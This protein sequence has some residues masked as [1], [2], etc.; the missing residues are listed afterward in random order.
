[1]SK[2]HMERTPATAVQC[3]EWLTRVAEEAI[4]G[5][6]DMTNALGLDQIADVLRMETLKQDLT[7]AI[8]EAT[9]LLMNLKA[10][11]EAVSQMAR[12]LM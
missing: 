6:T 12:D 4:K 9:I 2:K 10:R 3:F 7:T 1:M 11:A 5:E 8:N